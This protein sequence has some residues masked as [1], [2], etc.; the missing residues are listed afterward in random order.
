MTSVFVTCDLRWPAV[1]LLQAP[2]SRF[3]PSISWA[4]ACTAQHQDP[5]TWRLASATRAFAWGG[6]PPGSAL[7]SHPFR[8]WPLHSEARLQGQSRMDKTLSHKNKPARLGSLHLLFTLLLPQLR[9]SAALASSAMAKLGAQTVPAAACL[10]ATGTPP[11]TSQSL[12]CY[13]PSLCL[14]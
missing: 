12:Y 14:T 7:P 10:S 4:S 11:G 13:F 6:G 1:M 9:L 5:A 2:S 3:W 8:L